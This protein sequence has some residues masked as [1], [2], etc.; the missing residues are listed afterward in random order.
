LISP[1]W[2][3]VQVLDPDTL[4]PMPLGAEGLIA[5]L[6]LANWETASTLLTGDVGRLVP[7][8]DP[9]DV[10]PGWHGLPDGCCGLSLVGR[11]PQAAPKGCSLALDQLLTRS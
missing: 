9:D 3:A 11:A 2:C 4:D 5:L 6:D 8:D 10:P 7:A 1:P